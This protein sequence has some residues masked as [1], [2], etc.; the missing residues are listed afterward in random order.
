MT[1]LLAHADEER[2]IYY[3]D[4]VL[5][6]LRQVANVRLNASG[7]PLSG[8]EFVA[9][10]AGCAVIVGDTKARADAAVLAAL[11]DLVAY[12]HGHVDLR[13]VDIPTASANGI[14]VTHAGA[15]FAAPVA[16][17][18]LAFMIDLS[19]GI[20]RSTNLWRAGTPPR[21]ALSTQLAGH[22]VG[23]IGYGHIGRHL[24]ALARAIGMRVLVSDPHIA[25]IAEPGIEL[26]PFS[27]LLG[28]SEF[29]VP[30]APSTPETRNLIDATALAKMKPSAFLINVSRGE[31]VDEAALEDAL[32]R[33]VIA[34]A[35]LDVGLAPF[36]MPPD[37]LAT[38]PDVIATPHIGGVTPEALHAQA[39]DTVDQVAAIL[40]GNVPRGAVNA[41]RATRLAK[42]PVR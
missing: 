14:L 19:R 22:T 38:R 20:T 30:M 2:R 28:Q 15:H 27:E 31:L 16:E 11:P 17:L 3:A 12:V 41:E 9:A 6:R 39:S 26:V 13:H 34:G 42:L 24:A 5:A 1:I 8:R 37:R 25:A 33:G 23:I 10:A 21:T 40:S 7:K 4:D 35:A 29:V 18:V 36:Q 32:D